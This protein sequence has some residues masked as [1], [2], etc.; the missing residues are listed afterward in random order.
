MYAQDHGRTGQVVGSVRRR[1]MENGE[2]AMKHFGRI[3]KIVQ[4]L[5]SL[6]VVKSVADVNYKIILTLTSDYEMEERTIV[7]R[8]DVTRA[9]HRKHHP[10]AV[11]LPSRVEGQ[12]RGR[13]SIFDGSCSMWSCR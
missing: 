3:D 5:A 1:K 11:L 13:D 9:G 7:Y 2:E 12:G 6:G 8:E 10:T 4:V